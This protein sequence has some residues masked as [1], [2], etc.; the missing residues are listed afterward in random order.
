MKMFGE[1]F[2]EADWKKEKHIPVI[3]CA[4]KVKAGEFFPVK[5]T[6]GKEIPHPNTTAHH[7]S[8]IAVYFQAEGEKFPFEVGRFDFNAHGE[9]MDGPDKGSVY[10]VSEVTVNMKVTKP[11]V[12]YVSSQCN[13]HGL[14]SSQ[15][16]LQLG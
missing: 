13:L 5:V 15:K 16:E 12:I 6:V 3:E 4:E 11:G 1:L 8:W 7:I 9:S 10:T 2:Q 14:W